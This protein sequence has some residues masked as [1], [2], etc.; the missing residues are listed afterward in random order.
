M[1]EKSS[2]KKEVLTT[3]SKKKLVKAIC[4]E[5]HSKLD[6]KAPRVK[7]D[8]NY[9]QIR[10]LMW[11]NDETKMKFKQLGFDEKIDPKDSL[12][13]WRPEVI[14]EFKGYFKFDASNEDVEDVQIELSEE[15]EKYRQ[16]NFPES[17]KKISPSTIRVVDFLTFMGTKNKQKDLPNLIRHGVVDLGTWKLSNL[18]MEALNACRSFLGETKTA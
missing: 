7:K 18:K 2:S 9:T 10:E 4:Q 5:Y 11:L 1:A 16:E 6:I 14:A 13:K 15:F 3:S 17:K 8:L 12:S